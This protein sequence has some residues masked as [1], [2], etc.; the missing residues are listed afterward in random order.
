MALT[1]SI[2]NIIVIFW[3][4]LTSCE[5]IQNGFQTTVKQEIS[6][7]QFSRNSYRHRFGPT[8][9]QASFGCDVRVV[10]DVRCFAKS[11]VIHLGEDETLE[12]AC[13]FSR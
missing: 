12:D 4:V 5:A 7:A 2:K 10:C 11:L 8:W 3:A 1:K 9:M 13:L 6:I